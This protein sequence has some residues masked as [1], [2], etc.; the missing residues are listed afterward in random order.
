MKEFGLGSMEMVKALSPLPGFGAT[1]WICGAVTG[2]L[3]TLGLY[4]GS[5][6]ITNYEATGSAIMAA[7]KFMPRFETELGSVLCPKIQEDVIFGRYMDTR[8]SEENFE[9]FKREKGYAKCALP[10]GIGARLAAQVIIESM[11]K[12]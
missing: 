3:I 12:V 9:A 4:F 1:G 7:R 5:D 6:D 10:T 2:G 8:A 11:E